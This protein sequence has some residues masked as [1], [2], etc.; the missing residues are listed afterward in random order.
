MSLNVVHHQI[1]GVRV[2][3]V[4]LFKG[5]QQKSAKL[6]VMPFFRYPKRALDYLEHRI[7]FFVSSCH[8]YLWS[9]LIQRKLE[10]S[11]TNPMRNLNGRFL[12]LTETKPNA[13]EMAQPVN[14]H[15]EYLFT[16]GFTRRL[17]V[18]FSW[19]EDRRT[20]WISI[21][22]VC[23]TGWTAGRHPAVRENVQDVSIAPSKV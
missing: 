12:E 18:S 21:A 2:C 13:L 11:E 20:P 19:W 7:L 14:S 16:S 1:N 4:L 5:L 8:K 22:D 10:R 23:V 3:L 17:G 6:R 9:M 15:F